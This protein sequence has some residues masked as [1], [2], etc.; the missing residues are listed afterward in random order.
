MCAPPLPPLSLLLAHSLTRSLCKLPLRVSLFLSKAAA[1]KALTE[2]TLSRMVLP[3]PIFLTPLVATSLI[4]RLAPSVMKL[5]RAPLVSQF[6]FIMLGFGIGL[7]AAIAVF[8]QIGDMAI[9]D[10]DDVDSRTRASLK[11]ATGGSKVYYN[12]G[13]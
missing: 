5:P 11:A 13:L 9:D 6:L 7:P 3:L 12:K 2:M 8:P 10:L 1:R 4:T